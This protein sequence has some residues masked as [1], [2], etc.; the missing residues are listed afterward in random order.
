MNHV[1]LLGDSIFDNA[2]YIASFLYTNYRP[3]KSECQLYY[4]IVYKKLTAF[5]FE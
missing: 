2:A 4:N 3:K 5:L 1:V